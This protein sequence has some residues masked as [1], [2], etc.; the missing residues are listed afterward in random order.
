MGFVGA[1]VLFVLSDESRPV[2][3][4]TVCL[5]SLS[6]SSAIKNACWKSSARHAERSASSSAI[7]SEIRR[8]HGN[9]RQRVWRM[10]QRRHR[11]HEHSRSISSPT[12][13]I[14]LGMQSE[15][16]CSKDL[17]SMPRVW[18]DRCHLPKNTEAR[19]RFISR[20]NNQ[21][22]SRRQGSPRSRCGIRCGLFGS[23]SWLVKWLGP[24]SYH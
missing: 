4:V 1:F 2:Q 13:S 7:P 15:C 18:L 23:T 14:G 12:K 17:G 8:D 21:L 3:I 6:N 10:P 9:S 11:G 5:H 20:T 16:S 24:R 22:D 19:F